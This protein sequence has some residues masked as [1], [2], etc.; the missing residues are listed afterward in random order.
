MQ[1]LL[2]LYERF[3]LIRAEQQFNE[4]LVQMQS[5]CPRISRNGAILNKAG[6]VQSR[7][8]KYEDVD[9]CI[10]PLLERHGFAVTFDNP[11]F[12]GGVMIFSAQLR[13]IAGHKQDYTIS[14]P[15]DSMGAKN[16][17]QGAGST[18]SYARRYLLQMIFNIV[19]EGEDTDGT[20]GATVSEEQVMQIETALRDHRVSAER[21]LR[22]LQLDSLA[23]IP[24]ERFSFVM[25]S[26]SRA[27]PDKD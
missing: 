17:T 11:S 26:I 4:A 25:Q 24:S 19:T 20:G 10:R 3:H 2:D 9:R 7:Y 8:A 22:A 21:V 14:L 16:G 5:D 1:A 12:A 23:D 27:K 18:S 13:H 15:I 6:F